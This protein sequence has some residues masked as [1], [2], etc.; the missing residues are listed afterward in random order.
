MCAKFWRHEALAVAQAAAERGQLKSAVAR[1]PTAAARERS[2]ADAARAWLRARRFEREAV[3]LEALVARGGDWL[4]ALS[5]AQDGADALRDALQL[6]TRA[7]AQLLLDRIVDEFGDVDAPDS[8]D[9]AEP[10]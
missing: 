1:V 3:A 5:A 10:A 6:E 9:E 4:A 8:E 7:D 2:G